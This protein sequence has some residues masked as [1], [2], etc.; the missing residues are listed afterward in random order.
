MR[1][2]LELSAIF[3]T[4][5]L[6]C[7]SLAGLYRNVQAAVPA[8]DPYPSLWAPVTCAP[9]M[10]EQKTVYF[11]FDDGPSRNTEAVLDMLEKMNVKATF[12]VTGQCSD[13]ADV[14]ELLRRILRDGHEIGLHA[15]THNYGKVYGSLEGYLNELDAI[16]RLVV[17]STGY[18]ANILRF[19]GGSRTGNASKGLMKRIIAEIERR[20][21][22]Y[23]DW[24]VVSGDQDAKVRSA[25]ALAENIVKGATG[26]RVVV[27]LHDSPG[28]V[29]S[30]RAVEL[31][32]PRLR[33]M[34]YEFD[35]LTAQVEPIQ[36]R[37]P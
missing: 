4:A 3:F 24:D 15:Y 1:R 22:I 18:S 21:Y 32:I 6:L 27:L 23:Y 13:S 5:A 37:R 11:T 28:P 19:P 33:E 30:A 29:T 10:P 17:E 26:Q 36:F 9:S 12:F 8:A 31:A 35:R 16:N 7:V 2:K 20:H 25:E 14:P 34:G